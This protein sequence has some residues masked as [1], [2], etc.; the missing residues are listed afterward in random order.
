MQTFN[1]TA[2]DPTTGEVVKSQVKAQNERA[3]GKLLLDQGLIAPE[4]KAV[5]ES[6]G[7]IDQLNNRVGTKDRLIF[8]R[9]LA[10]LVGAGLPISQ[11]MRTVFDQTASKPMKKVVGD[12]VTSIEAGRSMREAFGGHPEVFNGLYLSLLE[13]GEASGTLDQALAKIADQEEKDAEMMS[14]IRSA[15]TY[16]AIVLVVIV[17]VIGFMMFQVVPQVQALYNDMGLALPFLTNV[18]VTVTNFTLRFW[19]LLAAV[20]G[21][22]GWFLFQ[23][24][25]TEGGIVAKDTFKLNMPVFKGMFR[26]LYMARFM[27]TGQTL[28][29]TGVPMLDALEICSASVNNVV[30]AKSIDAAAEK[31]KGGKALSAAVADQPYIIE[32]VPQMIKIGEQSGQIDEMM[33]KTAKVFED[34]LDAQIKTIQTL[35]EPVMMVILALVAG[36]LV[37]GVLM[38]IYQM[39]GKVRV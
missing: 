18:L 38:P 33:G 11:A 2:K 34:E 4:L 31:V 6:G 30:V 5:E 17:A 29:S 3:A 32:L 16:P 26:R 13:A 37:G 36:V 15:F 9:Q 7:I 27:R 19:W 20:L 8:T 23:Y 22:G 12:L 21:L 39:V 28:L 35:I 1:Y 25:K 10:T 24:F 14:K